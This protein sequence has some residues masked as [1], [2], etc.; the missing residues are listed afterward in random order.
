MARIN[1]SQ[2]LSLLVSGILGL[3]RRDW[4]PLAAQCDVY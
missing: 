4:Q 1:C 3:P 2:A